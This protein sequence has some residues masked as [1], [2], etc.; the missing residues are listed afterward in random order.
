[1]NP[2]DRLKEFKRRAKMMAA[3]E[4]RAALASEGF[5]QLVDEAVGY[6][7]A[8]VECGGHCAGPRPRCAPGS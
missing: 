1:M 5:R 3:D 4:R 8:A 7:R 2:S 6:A